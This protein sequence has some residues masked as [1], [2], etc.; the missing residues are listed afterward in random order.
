MYV[1]ACTHVCVC[2]CVYVV[3]VCVF[4]HVLCKCVCVC[5]HF[6]VCMCICKGVGVWVC[7]G[8]VNRCVGVSGWGTSRC[9]C[10]CVWVG[11]LVGVCGCWCLYT[12][13][14]VQCS[15]Y[16]CVHAHV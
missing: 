1:R 8:G 15:T 11:Y 10:G 12:S 16:V 4:V 13:E 6:I 2:V 7:S 14:H 9:V 3:C 5:A